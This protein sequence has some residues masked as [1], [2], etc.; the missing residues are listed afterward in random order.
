MDW[1]VV[2]PT[3]DVSF[4]IQ[5]VFNCLYFL[6]VIF[7]SSNQCQTSVVNIR[8]SVNAACMLIASYTITINQPLTATCFACRLCQIILLNAKPCFVCVRVFASRHWFD[9]VIPSRAIRFPPEHAPS[10]VA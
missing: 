5:F 2:I 8:C 9:I 6:C 1:R 4:V 10:T 7:Y 3:S